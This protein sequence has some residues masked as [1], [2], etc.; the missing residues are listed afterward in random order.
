MIFVSRKLLIC[1]HPTQKLSR[2]G[3]AADGAIV[4]SEP[5]QCCWC[6]KAII[7]RKKTG[8]KHSSTIDNLVI[9]HEHSLTTDIPSGKLT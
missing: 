1:D 6:I 7:V 4:Q 5:P 9:A 2:T 3:D 8:Y